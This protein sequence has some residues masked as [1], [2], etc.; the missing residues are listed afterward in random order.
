MIEALIA[1][2]TNPA[3]LASLAER[4]AK[5]NRLMSMPISETMTWAPRFLMPGVD[6]I[7]STAVR[8]GPRLASTCASS[9][10]IAGRAQSGSPTSQTRG[11]GGYR[12]RSRAGSAPVEA[13]TGN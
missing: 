6:T 3:K 13:T 10:A 11:S 12:H 7:N 8:K 2:E 9:V 5:A 4:Q 1:G